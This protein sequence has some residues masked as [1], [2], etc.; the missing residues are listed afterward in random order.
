[1][2]KTI[3]DSVGFKLPNLEAINLRECSLI[4]TVPAGLRTLGLLKDLKL[5]KNVLAGPIPSLDDGAYV[6][7]ELLTLSKNNL[8]GTVSSDFGMLTVLTDLRLSDNQLSGALPSE[9]GRL[10]GLNRL[11]FF[12]NSIVSTIPSSFGVLT[13]LEI[14]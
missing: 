12:G 14:L 6:A 1:M 9:I 7:L 13:N 5:H 8:T 10:I 4:G 3:P 11:T 2:N